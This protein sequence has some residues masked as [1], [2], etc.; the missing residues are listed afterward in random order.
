ME[1]CFSLVCLRVCMCVC[2]DYVFILV[3]AAI[4]IQFS[5]CISCILFSRDS[6]A[7]KNSVHLISCF[8]YSN[9]EIGRWHFYYLF[10][11]FLNMRRR[12]HDLKIAPFTICKTI[13]KQYSKRHHHCFRR[14]IWMRSKIPIEKWSFFSFCFAALKNQ[15][16]NSFFSLLQNVSN[17]CANSH[18]WP[19]LSLP[20]RALATH[21]CQVWQS[22]TATT[23]GWPAIADKNVSRFEWNCTMYIHWVDWP[24]PLERRKKRKNFMA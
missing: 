16:S 17:F 24:G 1:W 12:V 2:V 22:H 5:V 10:F 3:F 13:E 7:S 14:L 20:A 21:R 11:S 9:K 18:C 6:P 23:A 4:S 8:I 15:F 19:S